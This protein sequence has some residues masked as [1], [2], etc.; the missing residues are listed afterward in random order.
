MY[1]RENM[2]QVGIGFVRTKTSML[3]VGIGLWCVR[4]EAKL[5]KKANTSKLLILAGNINLHVWRTRRR[6]FMCR[7]S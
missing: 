7:V 5:I 1:V 4:K 2:Q 6:N 3:H